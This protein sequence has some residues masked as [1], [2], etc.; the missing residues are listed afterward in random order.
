MSSSMSLICLTWALIRSRQRGRVVRPMSTKKAGNTERTANAHALSV[1][2]EDGIRYVV[3]GF[4]G[5]V[6]EIGRG[7]ALEAAALDPDD[8]FDEGGPLG[9]VEL[10]AGVE[11]LGAARL[12]SRPHGVDGLMAVERV[13]R[14]T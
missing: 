14:V 4:A 5:R 3:G 7:G 12:M 6:P 11:D 13:L 8:G 1:G 9:V 2:G 10:T